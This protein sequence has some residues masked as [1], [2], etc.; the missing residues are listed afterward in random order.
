MSLQMDRILSAL[1]RELVDSHQLVLVDGADPDAL[2]SELRARMADAPPFQQAGGMLAG[3]M[4]ESP[5]VDDLFAS[6]EDI[7]QAL[8]GIGL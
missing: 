7:I 3:A 6:D 8:N 5:L 2:A 1:V 4:I